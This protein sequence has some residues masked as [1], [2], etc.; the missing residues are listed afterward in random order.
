MLNPAKVKIF[1]FMSVFIHVAFAALFAEVILSFQPP[2]LKKLSLT[3]IIREGAKGEITQSEAAWPMP[4]R[5]DPDF[6]PEAALKDFGSEAAEWI[7]F[8]APDPSLFE[9]KETLIPIIDLKKL[10]AKAYE[11][12]PKELF[13]HP[14]PE[15]KAMP[16]TDFVL[17]PTA[18]EIFGAD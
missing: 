12:P 7:D 4:R 2:Q 16:A 1:A 10:A 5:I 9:P 6:S 13:S 15:L 18:P 17:G 11:P 3:I 8:K 14:A